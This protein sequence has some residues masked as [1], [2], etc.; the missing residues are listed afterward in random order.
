MALGRS[1]SRTPL[2]TV[3]ESVDNLESPSSRTAP[4]FSKMHM[5]VTLR[6]SLSHRYFI[7]H[8]LSLQF[9]IF[10]STRSLTVSLTVLSL[11]TAL[12]FILGSAEAFVKVYVQTWNYPPAVPAKTCVNVIDRQPL[13][14]NLKASDDAQKQFIGVYITA[15][16][17]KGAFD[18]AALPYLIFPYLILSYCSGGSPEAVFLIFSDLSQA[19][20]ISI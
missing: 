2:L 17:T 11:T 1:V 9:F 15:L 8:S 7:F 6:H 18:S 14:I 12:E 10:S 16:P 13:V 20:C 5:I 4:I 3:S 19:S